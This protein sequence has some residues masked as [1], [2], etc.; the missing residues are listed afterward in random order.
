[1]RKL[2]YAGIGSRKTPEEVLRLMER[3]AVRLAERGFALRSGGAPGADQAF[4]RGAR[5]GGGA[6]EI[7]IP[8]PGYEGYLPGPEV[9]LASARA[10]LMAAELHPAWERLS[11]GVRKL[12]ARNC[13]QILGASLEDP[14]AFVIC[15]TPD[16]AESEAECGCETGGTGLAI[17]LASRWGVPVVNLARPGALERLA[18]LVE[19]SRAGVG[20]AW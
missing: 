11:N 9:A 17:R 6:V 15:W 1:M 16:G 3:I 10:T 4:E 5:Q 7:F 2:V 20:V 18:K 19:A 8:W 13:H 12:M 14:V